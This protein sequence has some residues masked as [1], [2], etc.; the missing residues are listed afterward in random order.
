[1]IKPIKNRVLVLRDEHEE[2]TEGGIIIPGKKEVPTGTGIV[3]AIGNEVDVVEV[4]QKVLFRKT[5]GHDLKVDGKEHVVLTDENL[6]G[7]FQ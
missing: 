1:M 3:V 7:V 2:K 5:D 4:G 6:M